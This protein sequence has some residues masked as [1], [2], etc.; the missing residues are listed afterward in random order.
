MDENP[1]KSPIELPPVDLLERESLDAVE[2]RHQEKWW[3]LYLYLHLAALILT[4]L[5]SWLDSSRQAPV[6]LGY[7]AR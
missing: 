4:G 7:C 1:Y 6:L 3:R 2:R 5:A